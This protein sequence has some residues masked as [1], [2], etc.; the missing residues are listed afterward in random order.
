MTKA[1]ARCPTTRRAAIYSTGRPHKRSAR[2]TRGAPIV[3]CVSR[4]PIAP[5]HRGAEAIWG[6]GADVKQPQKEGVL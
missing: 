2:R 6:K 5:A 3:Q 4:A 1:V